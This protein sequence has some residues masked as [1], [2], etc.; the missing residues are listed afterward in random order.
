MLIIRPEQMKVFE[1][2]ALSVF[3]QELVEHLKSFEPALCQAAGDDGVRQAVRLGISRARG[4]GF[5]TRGAICFYLE[6]MFV[7]GSNFDT[8]PQLYWASET[9][10]DGSLGDELTRTDWLRDRMTVYLDEVVGEDNEH[11]IAA[12]RRLNALDL[13]AQA[14]NTSL[15]TED[16]LKTMASIYPEKAA[17]VGNDELR[18]LIRRSSDEATLYSLPSSG[19]TATLAGLKLALGHGICE[20]PLYP[21]IAAT[22]TDHR[23]KEGK[24]RLERLLRKMR[25]YL[26][27]VLVHLNGQK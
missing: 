9:L 10:Q 1:A 16:I 14:A 5:T 23:I 18:K 6:L 19:G 12:L 3:E 2:L 15:T 20:D 17:F 27:H 4:Y 13:Q 25:L 8:D 26:N 22:L 21:W 7:C 11:S 24:A